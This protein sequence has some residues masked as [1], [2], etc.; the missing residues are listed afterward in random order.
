MFVFKISWLPYMFIIGGIAIAA[1]GQYSALVLVPIGIVWLVIKY[2][3]RSSGS[4]ANSAEVPATYVQPTA[5]VETAASA[6]NPASA[7]NHTSAQPI[8]PSETQP[9]PAHTPK[10]CMNCGNKLIPGSKF[11]PECGQKL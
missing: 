4:N 11:C 1:E 6:E 7:E 10:F 2:G 9:A 5:P 8:A 3:S